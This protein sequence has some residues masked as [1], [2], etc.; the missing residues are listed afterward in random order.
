VHVSN[1]IELRI[2][3]WVSATLVK[4]TFRPMLLGLLF[5]RWQLNY[6]YAS[7]RLCIVSLGPQNFGL[8][9]A[10]SFILAEW[11][12][13]TRGSSKWSVIRGILHCDF[14]SPADRGLPDLHQDFI[15]YQPVSIYITLGYRRWTSEWHLLRPLNYWSAPQMSFKSPQEMTLCTTLIQTLYLRNWILIGHNQPPPQVG[16][17]TNW[18]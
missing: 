9:I 18:N 16:Y 2:D 17:M 3:D 6:L 10:T 14:T 15:L 13:W 4:G 7:W 1:S 8:W 11:Q 5:G 12:P